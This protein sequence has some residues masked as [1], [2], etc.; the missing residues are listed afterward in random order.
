MAHLRADKPADQAVEQISAEE[1]ADKLC[2]SFVD[3]GNHAPLLPHRRGHLPD[4][5]G[6]HAREGEEHEENGG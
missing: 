6:E 1:Q 4:E 2:V 5:L 3:L